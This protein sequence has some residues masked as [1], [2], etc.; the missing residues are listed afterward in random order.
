MK[1]LLKL[2]ETIERRKLLG[3]LVLGRGRSNFEIFFEGRL[4]YVPAQSFLPKIDLTGLEKEGVLGDKVP[5]ATIENLATR[6]DLSA[7]IFPETLL[8]RGLIDE[9]VFARLASLHLKEEIFARLLDSGSF[10]FQEGH[11]PE[12]LIGETGVTF[13]YPT[14]LEGFLELVR[15]RLKKLQSMSLLV[16]ADEEV[17]VITEKG[18]A[19]RQNPGLQFG[20]RK[21]LELLDGFRT[22]RSIIDDSFLFKY[23]VERRISQLLV[24]GWIKKTIVPEIQGIDPHRL[25]QDEA[26]R[27]VPYFKNAIKYGTDELKAREGYAALAE[28]LGRNNEAVVQYNFIGDTLYQMGRKALAIRAYQKA[29]SLSR[30]EPLISDKI[31]RIYRENA[32]EAR[33]EG[34]INDAAALYNK[35]LQLYPDNRELFHALL[36]L[37]ISKGMLNDVA[38]L[39]DRAANVSRDSGNA[40]F[41][42]EILRHVCSRC[43]GE[44]IFQK[45]LINLYLDFGMRPEAADEMEKLARHYLDG[46]QTTQGLDLIDKVLRLDPGRRHLRRLAKSMGRVRKRESRGVGRRLVSTA[47]L[48]VILAI[49]L[50][51]LWAFFEFQQI[52]S[53]RYL[54]YA[55]VDPSNVDLVESGRETKLRELSR[56]ATEFQQRFRFSVLAWQA[57]KLEKEYMDSAVQ[58]ERLRN[59]KKKKLIE[60]GRAL[61]NKGDETEA[62]AMLEKLLVLDEDDTWRQQA[63]AEI[64]RFKNYEREATELRAR[65][66]EAVARGDLATAHRLIEQLISHYQVASAAEGVTFPVEVITVPRQ[67]ADAL[68]KLPR[69]LQMPPSGTRTFRLNPPG[70]DP[71]VVKV[72]AEAGPAAVIFFNQLPLWSA[73]LPPPGA[74]PLRV[75][76]NRLFYVDSKGSLHVI[77]LERGARQWMHDPPALIAPSAPILVRR[78]H[79]Y[80]PLNNKKILSFRIDGDSRVAETVEVDG[81][82]QTPL[83]TREDGSSVLFGTSSDKVITWVPLAHTMRSTRIPETPVRI[84]PCGPG[85]ITM[86]GSSG[87]VYRL[88]T[89]SGRVVWKSAFR[90]KYSQGPVV[91]GTSGTDIFVLETARGEIIA[92]DG[93]SGNIQWRRPPDGERAAALLERSRRILLSESSGVILEIDPLTNA[94]LA[95]HDFD[96]L[97]R[98]FTRV[99][100]LAQ[101]LGFFCPDGS[102]MVVDPETLKP[103]WRFHREKTRIVSAADNAEILALVD[104]QG[105]VAAFRR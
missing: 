17:F 25:S 30:D 84:A 104:D 95:R 65:A 60:D 48:L 7:T 55:S 13:Q 77:D 70:Y 10:R 34:K 38:D 56:L 27:Y 79:F 73:Q 100:E 102:F 93:E 18:M 40:E 6:V 37:Y 71:V 92:L 2:L 99:V 8:S 35:A 97:V 98:P 4:L 54:I 52:S 86:L 85:E 31:I 96:R 29:F 22:L 105:T 94:V 11:V 16:P 63:E 81:F 68:D 21:I 23:Y 5:Q 26:T 87:V 45:K 50:Y 46:G 57:E 15:N 1:D 89:E 91:M 90:G 39:C 62:I 33:A 12:A 103:L 51:Q 66:D 76:E 14:K 28:R 49:T 78:P 19:S 9:K 47:A 72:A 53:E 43:E 75:T 36:D 41:A 24:E 83:V 20:Y 67:V 88:E 61:F 80:L 64:R 58:I 69:R 74:F 32:E 44:A 101:S 42:V 82:I 3:T 59:H